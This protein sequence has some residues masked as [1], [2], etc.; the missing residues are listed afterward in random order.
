MAS[1]LWWHPKEDQTAVETPRVS[2]GHRAGDLLLSSLS[3][4]W[5][6]TTEFQKI[7]TANGPRAMKRPQSHTSVKAA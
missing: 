5:L 3:A 1:K 7:C 2:G 4:V 6:E